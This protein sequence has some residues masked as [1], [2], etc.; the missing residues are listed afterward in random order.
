MGR[1]LCVM[2]QKGGV[3]KTTT[4]INLGTGLAQQG[5]KVLLIDLDPQANLTSALGIR[6]QTL[7]ATVYDL[8]KGE[9]EFAEV[10]QHYQG[11]DLIPSNVGLSGADIEL[12]SVVGRELLL[13]EAMEGAVD[14][15]D[16]ILIDCSPTLGLLSLNALT[17]ADQVL[18][19]IQ[20]EYL[21]LEGVSYLM[22]TIDTVR[23]RLNRGLRVGGVIVTKYES[24]KKLHREVVELI[25]HHFQDKMFDTLVRN[26]VSLAEAPSFGQDIFA[27]KPGSIGAE[28]YANL[29]KE[30]LKREVV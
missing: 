3:G 14:A 4:T 20:P 10:V 18:I 1:M 17:A 29:C 24:R 22:Q 8:L 27:Y 19:T 16:C 30:I 26:N 21:P 6:P 2:N 13:K 25:R 15:Y 5:K 12:S 7:D 28:D 23:T 9:A 11:I